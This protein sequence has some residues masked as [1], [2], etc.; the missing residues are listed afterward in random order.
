MQF[1]QSLPLPHGAR[2]GGGGICEANDGG[3][4]PQ[5]PARSGS[6]SIL[7][8]TASFA[9][10]V[11]EREPFGD[12]TPLPYRHTLPVKNKMRRF[13]DEIS[14]VRGLLARCNRK[15]LAAAN[16]QSQLSPRVIQIF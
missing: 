1:P 15:S 8:P 13:Q 6:C 5:S 11:P 14:G 10:G 2:Q 12:T 4:L 9:A 3:D 16:T 7:L